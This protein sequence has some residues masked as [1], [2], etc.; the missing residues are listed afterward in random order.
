MLPLL[1]L[2]SALRLFIGA[3]VLLS[4]Y[5]AIRTYVLLRGK[6]AIRELIWEHSD[7]VIVRDGEGWEYK[8]VVMADSFVHPWAVVLSLRLRA[9]PKIR[10]RCMDAVGFVVRQQQSKGN[11]DHPVSTMAH[12]G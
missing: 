11:H 3:A 10:G 9:Y 2:L 12:S 8:V 6:H 5:R 1:A 4:L 7:H